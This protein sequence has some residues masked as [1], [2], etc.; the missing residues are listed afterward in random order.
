M[1]RLAGDGI[2]VIDGGLVISPTHLPNLQQIKDEVWRRIKAERDRRTEAGGCKVGSAWFH[3]DT[4]SRS[5]QLGL[6]FTMKSSIQG[7]LWKTMD[8]S[9][10]DMTPALASEIVTASTASDQA[11]FAAAEA[12]KVALEK[13][14]DP[15]DYDFSTGWPVIFRETSQETPRK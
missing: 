15:E 5:Q 6:A 1:N 9:F 14:E 4:K 11:I 8:G 13:S 3:S 7:L 12:H 2:D 10:L